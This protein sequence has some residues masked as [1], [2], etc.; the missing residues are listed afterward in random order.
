[1]IFILLAVIGGG[2]AYIL[3]ENKDLKNDIEGLKATTDILLKQISSN[4]RSVS[5]TAVA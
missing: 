3:T 4:P 1:L 2:C 5:N